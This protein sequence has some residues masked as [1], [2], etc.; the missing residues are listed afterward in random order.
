VNQYIAPPVSPPPAITD[1]EMFLP[2]VMPWARACAEMVA[3]Q[4][5]RNAAIEFCSRT[6]WWKYEPAPIFFVPD[7]T[8][9]DVAIPDGTHLVLLL[10]AYNDR[11]RIYIRTSDQLAHSHVLDWRTIDASQ[12]STIT[13]L[14]ATQ[15]RI[16]PVPNADTLQ[17][18][19]L[20]LLVAL[21]PSRTST[22]VLTEIYEHYAETIAQGALARLYSQMET[23]YSSPQAMT[24]ARQM[25]NAGVDDARAEANRAYG[26][27]GITVQLSRIV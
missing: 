23:P 5:I 6:N 15:I 20:S 14:N 25:F 9:Y 13:Q 10:Q 18:T 12:A 21:A 26:R 19:G 2:E 27:V 22:G 4:A 3:I 7:Q 8:D 24:V 17:E 11:R 1:Y 16:L